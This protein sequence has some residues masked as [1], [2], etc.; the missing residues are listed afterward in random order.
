MTGH[1]IE[2]FL[3]FTHPDGTEAADEAVGFLIEEIEQL[4][5]V[6]LAHPQASAAPA[7]SRSSG[8]EIYSSLIL[9]LAG[10]PAV[11]SLVLLAQDWLARRNSGTIDISVGPHRITLTGGTDKA[12]R[13]AVTTFL[14]HLSDDAVGQ[15]DE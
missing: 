11:R 6:S 10:A 3:R 13:E 5:I 9:G 4:G 14:A 8:A 1:H 2:V 12:R 15:G 7:G